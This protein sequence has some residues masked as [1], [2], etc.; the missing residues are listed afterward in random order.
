LVASC[1]G[2]SGPKFSCDRWQIADAHW[3]QAFLE[4][5]PQRIFDHF[6]ES[7]ALIYRSLLG[8]FEQFI[9]DI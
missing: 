2:N 5:K 9:V 7:N 1:Y 4:R 6:R 8:V 3:A